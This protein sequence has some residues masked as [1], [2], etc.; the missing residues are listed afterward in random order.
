MDAPRILMDLREAGETCSKHRVQ[1]LMRENGMRALHGYRI[2]RNPV[3]K[4]TLLIP[5]IL[6]RQFTVSRPNEVW[7]TDITYIRT[8]QGWLYL[9]V[10]INPQGRR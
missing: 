1:R 9:A 8:W 5:N 10:V 2:R 7:V 6:Q 4:P 3:T